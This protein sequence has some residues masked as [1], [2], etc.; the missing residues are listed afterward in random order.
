LE[1]AHEKDKAVEIRNNIGA[2]GYVS[3]I[4]V[5]PYDGDRVMVSFSSYE[6]KSIF[7]SI[8][9]GDSWTDISGNLEE[10]PGGSGSGPSVRSVIIFPLKVGYHYF[11]GTSTG[12][13]STSQLDGANTQWAQEGSETIGNVVVDMITGR[14][15]DGYLAIA[16]H[17]N[18]IYTTFVD[19]DLLAVNDAE[20]PAEFELSQNYPN[21]FNPT[22][23]IS[24]NLKQAGSVTLKVF[25]LMGKEVATL[26]NGYQESGVRQ[27]IW[28]GKDGNGNGMPSGIY[29]YRL[30]VNGLVLT[31]KMQLLK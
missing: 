11:A 29:F 23:T 26:V 21:P 30:E 15:S 16:T 13:Y 18:G 22:T 2:F 25:D 12:L 31:K 27:A 19:G 6:T 1:D 7:Y 9:G 20:I 17:G 28:S 14:P 5:D 24:F 4:S 3:S 8:N 10:N